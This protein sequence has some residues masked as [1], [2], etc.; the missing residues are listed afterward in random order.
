[1]TGRVEQHSPRLAGLVVRDGCTELDERASAAAMSSQ[2]RSKWN[3]L[4]P[5]SFGHAGGWWSYGKVLMMIEDMLG[6]R[7]ITR[8]SQVEERHGIGRRQLEWLFA[9]YVGVG[10]KWVLGRY[11]MHDVIVAL[12][13]G[14]SPISPPGSAGSPRRISTAISS[15]R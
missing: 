9:R 13:G 14:Y 8:A 7:A 5:C 12:D 6:D 2:A 3:C 1:M 10:P 11:R 4:V 15:T